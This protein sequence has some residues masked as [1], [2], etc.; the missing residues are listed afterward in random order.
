MPDLPM[1][2]F[3]VYQR[4]ILGTSEALIWSEAYYQP[5]WQLLFDIFNSLP[6]LGLAALVSWRA[7]AFRL[8]AFIT[9]M[10]LHCL[11]DLPLHH[12]DAHA[13]FLPISSWRFQSPVSYWDAQHHGRLVAAVEMAFVLAGAGVLVLRSRIRAWQVVGALSLA[14]YAL[15][16]AFA[17]IVWL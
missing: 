10:I 2:A 12:D 4:A 16:I 11:A 8:L 17:V 9:N 1:L 15:F 7:R 14:S 3:Y 13:H 5:N 6:L